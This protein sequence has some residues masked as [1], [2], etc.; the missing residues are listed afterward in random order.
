[1]VFKNSNVV[2]SSSPYIQNKTEKFVSDVGSS[3]FGKN[4][5]VLVETIQVN[6]VWVCVLV[7]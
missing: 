1:M 3:F 4:Y 6:D 7:E 2:T 5:Q